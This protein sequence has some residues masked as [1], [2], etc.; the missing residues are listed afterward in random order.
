MDGLLQFLIDFT[1]IQLSL[2]IQMR[3]GRTG[4]DKIRIRITSLCERMKLLVNDYVT[5]K[6]GEICEVD[7]AT[8]IDISQHFIDSWIVMF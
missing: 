1:S 7:H 4:A 6:D 2:Y 5:P 8:D 3:T